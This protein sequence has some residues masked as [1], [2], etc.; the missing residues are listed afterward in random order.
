[1]AQYDEP[2]NSFVNQM[3]KKM[4]V[5][6]KVGQMAQI[7][8]D[9][10]ADTSSKNVFKADAAI[11][12]EV[13]EKYSIG[14]V[15]NTFQNTAMSTSQWNQ[16]IA[17]LRKNAGSSRLGIPIIYGFDAI[18]GATYVSDA[19]MF[20]QP[21]N[22]AASWNPAL[23]RKAAALTASTSVHAG[24]NWNF[25]PVLD[26]AWNPQWPRFWE[27]LGEDPY[28]IS[29]L[30][31]E[32][33]LGYQQDN[34]TEGTYMASCLKHFVGYSDP[35]YGKDRTNA[36]IPEHYLREY[37]L[38]GFKAGVQAGAKTV[39]LNSA[40]INGIPTHMN[41]RLITDILKGEMGFTGLVVTDW[42]DIDN[43]CKRDKI[44]SSTKE[45]IMLAINAG[46]D[47]AMIPYDYR[48]FCRELEELVNEGKV[49]MSRIDDAVGRILSVKH[50][51]GLF[52]EVKPSYAVSHNRRNPEDE[53]KSAL[54]L[55]QESLVLLKNQASILPLRKDSKILV[56]G[57]NANSMRTLNG[58][59]TYSWQGEK[60]DIF[61]EANETI[62]E[63]I[64]DVF[65]KKQVSYGEG[66]SYKMSGRYFEDSLHDLTPLLQ[67]AKNADAIVIC[68]GENSYTEKPGDLN[69]L[70]LSENQRKLIRSMIG[71]GKKIILILNEGRP[72]LISEFESNVSAIVF[73]GLPGNLGGEA[74][75]QLLAGE[76]N[77]SGKLPFT[78]PM[79]TNSLIPYIHKPSDE[80]SNPQ[81]MY[82]YS[83]DFHPQ[84]PF[85]FGLS[86]TRFSY[87]QLTTDKD[88]YE[89]GDTMHLVV[90][91]SNVGNMPGKEVV[92]IFSSDLHASLSPDVIRLKA[93]EKIDLLPGERKEVQLNIPVNSLSFVG[94]DNKNHLESGD[95]M[96][97]VNEL[98][99]N[100]KLNQSLIW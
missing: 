100:I 67:Y 78:Y 90:T 13:F 31:T 75:A 83:A 99:K 18:H 32:V 96:I 93:F 24:I 88:A 12:K 4:S 56:C 27:T 81:G 16:I 21:I 30:G 14:S 97:Q 52:D 80:N 40:M 41:K 10:L 85:G 87:D 8:L 71:T 1:M 36:W 64:Q 20:P 58:G 79:H 25:S 28:L 35:K 38:P 19:I 57:P 2:G 61:S 45:A 15:L 46:V 62:L 66:V 53:K 76:F 65:G 55:A 73:A 39:M 51:L 72:R 91:V 3:L 68:V 92:Q 9:V 63:A 37:H 5:N 34:G 22:Q 26:V 23:V 43:I 47:M 49:P 29:R 59:W 86:Y 54:Q 6:E 84:Y 77:P 42:Q 69:D 95:F 7:T 33:I 94:T 70:N 11:V 60:A 17:S 44:V 74:V 48:T 98:R 50:E 89:P 82:D